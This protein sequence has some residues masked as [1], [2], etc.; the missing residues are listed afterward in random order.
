MSDLD[1]ADNSSNIKLFGTLEI[2]GVGIFYA[3]A[4][5]SESRRVWILTERDIFTAA[6]QASRVVAILRLFNTGRMEGQG[7]TYLLTRM[8]D[9]I[10]VMVGRTATAKEIKSSFYVTGEYASD[11]GDNAMIRFKSTLGGRKY[12][13]IDM[14]YEGFKLSV[15]QYKQ[16]LPVKIPKV[17]TPV[18]D[19]KTKA[20]MIAG[21]GVRSFSLLLRQRD[22]ALDWYK[23]KNY[24][25]IDSTEKFKAMMLEFLRDVQEAHDNN[26]AILTCLDTETTGLNMLDLKPDNPMRDYIVAIPFG[27][28]NDVAYVICTEMYYFSNVERD[29]IYPLFNLLFSRNKDY[30]YQDIK[31]NYCGE[32]FSFSRKSIVLVGANVGFDE[33]AFFCEGADVFFDEDIQIM[34]YIMATDWVQGKNSLKYMTHRYLGDET[35][36]LEDLFGPQHKDKYRYLSDPELALVYGGADADYPRQLWRKLRRLMPDNLYYLYKKYDMTTRY[37]TAVATWKGM[38]VDAKGVQEQGQLVIEDLNAL[39]EFIYRYAYAANR[40]NLDEKAAKL[41]AL[42]GLDTEAEVVELGSKEGMYRYPFTPANHKNLLFN[43]LGYPVIKMSEKS[44]TPALDKFVL[45]KLSERKRETPVEFLLEDIPSK[46]DPSTPLVSKDDFNSDMYPLA[47]VFQTYAK[48]NKEYTAYYKP[49]MQN[50]LEGRMF[51]NFSLQRAATRRILSPGQTMKGSLKKLVIAPPGKL[52]MC[53]DASQIEYRHMASLAYIQTKD[54]LQREHPND[55]EQRLADSGIARIHRMMHNEEADYHIETAS[56]MTGLPQY[57]VDHDTRKMYKSIG[58]GIPYG[59][60]DRSMCESLF[61]KISKENMIK[62]KQTLDDYKARQFEII[63]LLETVRDSAFVPAK[64]PD[65]F[66]EML[67]IGDTHVGIVRNFVG[68]YRL[69]ILEKLTRA[70]TGRIRRQAGNC[71]IQG[72]AAELFRRMLYNFYM[73]CVNAGISDQVQWEMLVHDEVDT[74]ID[75]DI[76]VCKLIDVL[77]T[78]CTLRYTDHIPYYIGIGFGHDWHDAKDDAAELPVIMVNRLVT[79][80][81]DGKFA[82]PSDGQQAENLLKLK[83]HYMCDRVGEE[84]LSLIPDLRAGY[85][86]DDKAVDHV[87]NNLTNYTVR[88]YLGTFLTKED[89]SLYGKKNPAPLKLQLERW[90]Q[91]REAYGFGRT[92]LEERLEDAREQIK[93][94]VL[95]EDSGDDVLDFS[96]DSNL[97]SMRIELLENVDDDEAKVEEQ[98][99]SSWFGEDTLFDHSLSSDSIL[100]EDGAEEGYRYYYDSQDAEEE[101]AINDNPTNAYDLYV[102]NKYTREHIF[103]LDDSGSRYSVLVSGTPYSAKVRDL[104]REVKSSFGTGTSTLILIGDEVRKVSSVDCSTENLDVLDKYICGKLSQI[105][106]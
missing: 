35:L 45:K 55:W 86:W 25:L 62:T 36:E 67:D 22:K 79:A 5:Q 11:S 63:R 31:L 102:S 12:L 43:V 30:T 42:L 87:A 44:Q 94:L 39:K 34:H 104:A 64:I 71:I 33:C 56:M 7:K 98:R 88:S 1:R 32:K 85:T 53:F 99:N 89:K 3:F 66:R 61:G 91:A 95:G 15:S 105:N 74:I 24:V 48:I 78:S 18:E 29:E 37:R 83:R 16:Q 28:K 49:I 75:A 6:N 26:R 93:T 69:F 65:E 92:F 50:D 8:L 23:R 20:A 14:V 2:E 58:F 77:Q 17:M 106:K 84:L 13:E 19:E 10:N 41:S 46:A 38:Y 27:W 9:S 52:F 72:G 40:N 90:Q 103:S 96:F 4:S 101:Y 57:M 59:L 21:L 80:Y 70:R 97:D 47:R 68:F 73:G 82:I 54:L 51:Y 60:G 76:D 100:P 81:R